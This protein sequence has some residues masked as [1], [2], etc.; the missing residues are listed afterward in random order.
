VPIRFDPAE[1]KIPH[2]SS[3]L[4]GGQQFERLLAEFKAVVE[5]QAIHNLS[6]DDIAT[7]TGPQKLNNASN[8]AWAVR[9]INVLLN[10]LYS[11]LISLKSKSKR[12]CC[13][14]LINYSRDP[15]LS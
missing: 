6:L 2:A 11:L 8:I 13:L 3:K 15:P 7:A 1:W 4:Y 10:N 9:L 12:F 5:H 14:F